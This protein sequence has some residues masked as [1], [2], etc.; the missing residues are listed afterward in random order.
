MAFTEPFGSS[1]PSFAV[2]TASVAE[3]APRAIVTERGPA[4]PA[5]AK[6]PCCVT[7]RLTVRAVVVAPRVLTVKFAV[8]PST[9]LVAAADTETTGSSSRSVI[10][11]LPG[12]PTE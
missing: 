12:V 11:M 4:P 10:A 7:L 9:M 5:A 2:P 1:V 3:L 6:S 8:A